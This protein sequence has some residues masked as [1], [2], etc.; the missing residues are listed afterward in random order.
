MAL[1]VNDRQEWINAIKANNVTRINVILDHLSSDNRIYLVNGPLQLRSN[2]K[3]TLSNIDNKYEILMKS[4]AIELAIAYSSRDVIEV[5]LNNGLDLTRTRDNCGTLVHYIIRLCDINPDVEED[6]VDLYQWFIELVD[7]DA[8]LSLLSGEN[9]QGLRPV[10]LAA[11]YGFFKLVRAIFT[12]KDV[13]LIEEKEIGALR[14]QRFDI[15]DYEG[16]EGR[17]SGK[18]PLAFMTFM[19][20]NCLGKPHIA[21]LF[22]WMPLEQWYKMKTMPCWPLVLTWV[23]LRLSTI[24]SYYLLMGSSLENK[25]SVYNTSNTETVD[26]ISWC[27]DDKDMTVGI[28][29]RTILIWYITIHSTLVICLDIFEITY[30]SVYHQPYVLYRMC[31]QRRN[32]VVSLQFHR[33]SQHVLSWIFLAGGL[34]VLLGLDSSYQTISELINVSAAI[35]YFSSLLYFLQ[36]MPSIGHNIITIQ[37][38]LCDLFHFSILFIMCVLPF[39]RYFFIFFANNSNEGC[40]EDFATVIDSLYSSFTIMLNMVNFS[41]FDVENKNIVRLAHFCF[42]FI[43]AILLVNFLIALMS[44][45]ASEISRNKL[46]VQ[47]L[48][49]LQVAMVLEFR[50]GWLLK[51]YYDWMKR[52]SGLVVEKKV[53]LTNVEWITHTKKLH[54]MGKPDKRP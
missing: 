35:G 46:L 31:I 32:T 15:T 39:A 4:T 49:R 5:L 17:R 9:Q 29:F 13:Y 30:I 7:Q 54:K 41:E 21:D 18:S 44:N 19:N 6:L 42:V 25:V 16:S 24:V 33:I 38:M 2:A 3:P 51:R 11:E 23:M 43:V 50:L 1:D 26:E 20:E 53:L 37:R 40:I 45:S 8:K 48:E 10:E 47:K 28:T 36:V 22:S 52:H 27:D 12:T 14:Y 34:T